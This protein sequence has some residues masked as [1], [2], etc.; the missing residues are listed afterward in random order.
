[1][2]GYYTIPANSGD[3]KVT[4]AGEMIDTGAGEGP[5]VTKWSF[6]DWLMSFFKKIGDFFK[7]LFS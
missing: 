2:D 3:V 4:I 1:M 7:G 6:W 5:T